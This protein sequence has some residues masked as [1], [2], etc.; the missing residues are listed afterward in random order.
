MVDVQERGLGLQSQELGLA[1]GHDQV[2]HLLAH[3]AEQP[4]GGG[5]LDDLG[6]GMHQPLHP[7]KVLQGRVLGAGGEDFHP[8]FP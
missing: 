4:G 7:V 6:I 8:Q 1:A 5:V 3:D 2:R